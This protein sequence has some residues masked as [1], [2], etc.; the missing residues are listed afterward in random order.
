MLLSVLQV[1]KHKIKAMAKGD[2]YSVLDGEEQE[3]KPG[4]LLLKSLL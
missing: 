4:G 3:S 2:R 1:G